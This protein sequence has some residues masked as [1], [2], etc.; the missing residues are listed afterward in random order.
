MNEF[1]FL[2]Q[3]DRP[4]TARFLSMIIIL[5][6]LVSFALVYFKGTRS[7][8]LLVATLTALAALVFMIVKL[9]WG[10]VQ[11]FSAEIA[12]M[13]LALY[14]MA[15]GFFLPGIMLLLFAFS[16]LIYSRPQKIIFNKEQIAYPSFPAK[17]FSWKQVNQVIL[18]D[19][20]LSID[21]ADNRLLQVI[22]RDPGSSAETFNRFCQEQVNAHA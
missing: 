5:V 15:A 4:G 3:K 2:V 10:R 13:V 7:P 16:G 8:L 6:N 12:I 11:R 14:W 22:I 17:H 19:R 9:F 20:V 1:I 21:L 18:K